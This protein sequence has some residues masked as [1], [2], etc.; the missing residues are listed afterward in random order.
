MPP[1]K[2]TSG[3]IGPSTSTPPV[4]EQMGG[5][6]GSAGRVDVDMGPSQPLV[7]QSFVGE[8]AHGTAR[9]KEKAAPPAG[10]AANSQNIGARTPA[11]VHTPHPSQDARDGQ[12]HG[13]SRARCSLG[14]DLA[15]RSQD[16]QGHQARQPAA[17]GGVRSLGRDNAPSNIVGSHSISRSSHRSPP[18][19]AAEALAR[20]QLLLDFPPTADKLEDWRATIQSLIG[21]ANGDVHQRPSASRP[22][23]ANSAHAGGDKTGGGATT[24]RSPAQRQR[25]PTRRVNVD[26][27]STASSDPR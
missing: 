9:S 21:F 22:R 17:A 7:E 23:Q 26:D 4:L 25:S 6:V 8:G 14:G 20:A 1:K 24:V 19:T 3:A 5:V 16:G 15:P 27:D 10:G 13:A 2:K 18:A 12:R 11:L